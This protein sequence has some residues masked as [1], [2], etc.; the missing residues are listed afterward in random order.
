MHR[1][2]VIGRVETGGHVSG[3]CTDDPTVQAAARVW[4]PAPHVPGTLNVR[5]E[6][7]SLAS[8]LSIRARPWKVMPQERHPSV[9]VCLYPA[10]LLAY[11]RVVAVVLDS[12][13]YPGD[14]MELLAPDR[15]RDACR[16]IDGC[17]VEMAFGVGET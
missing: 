1:T 3:K 6:R 16:L 11:G 14:L 12:T 9:P 8:W 13:A 7:N 4:L 15:L 2:V 17:V 5:V 10:E